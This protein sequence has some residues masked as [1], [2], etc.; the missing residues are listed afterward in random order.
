MQTAILHLSDIHVQISRHS[1]VSTYAEAIADAVHASL[2]T[3]VHTLFIAVTGDVA[4]SG[5]DEE[6]SIAARFFEVLEGHIRTHCPHVTCHWIIVPGNHDADFETEYPVRD[7]LLTTLSAAAQVKPEIAAECL[8]PFRAFYEMQS[9]FISTGTPTSSASRIAV[10]QDFTVD[11]QTIT[12]CSINSAW[13]AQKK[14]AQGKL[15]LPVGEI[16]ELL[17]KRAA[18]NLCICLFHHPLNWF[19][20]TNARVLRTALE[21][22]CDMVLT[23]PRTRVRFQSQVRGAGVSQ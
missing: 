5:Q 22:G 3:D 18:S 1:V 4:W 2:P 15:C 8:K 21:Q 14:E 9:R 10:L 17:T 16:S 11:G 7:Q 12:F 20:A 19:E 23:G 13:M 6:Y